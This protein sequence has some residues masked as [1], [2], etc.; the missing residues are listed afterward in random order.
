[1]HLLLEY[2][3]IVPANPRLIRRVANAWAMLEALRL[4]LGHNEPDDVVVRAA[5]LFVQYPSLVDLLLDATVPP[6]LQESARPRAKPRS[7][8]PRSSEPSREVGEGVDAA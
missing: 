4:H 7:K 6:D 2:A 8:G 3:E 5:I 1:M